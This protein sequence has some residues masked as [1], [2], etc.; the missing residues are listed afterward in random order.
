[1]EMKTESSNQQDGNSGTQGVN[2]RTFV[3]Q[4]S[5]TAGSVFPAL[6]PATVL[7]KNPPSERIQLAAFGFGTRGSYVNTSMAHF[8]DARYVAVCDAFGSRRERA[9]Q[10]LDGL[11]GGDYVK[12]YSNPWDV[13]ERNDIDA[14]VICTPDHW[15]VP[16]AIAAAKAKK[17]MYVE[18]PLSYAMAW[19]WRLRDELKRSGGVF[20]YGTMQRSTGATSPDMGTNWR[21]DHFRNVCE[22]VRNGYIGKIQR[23]DVW[24]PDI[25]SQFDKFSCKQWGSLRPIEPPP[26]LDV[27]LWCGPSPLR[28]YT[29]DRCTG[30]GTCHCEESSLGFI[31]GWGAHPLDTMQWGLDTDNTA[32]VYY[33]GGGTIPKFGL[34]RTVDTWDVTCYYAN[35]ISVRF[36]SDRVAKEMLTY[37]K[38]WSIHGTTFFGTDG[39]ISVDRGG[40]EAS[41]ESLLTAKLGP[42]DKPLYDSGDHGRNFL[43][44][45]RSRKPT[46]S[47]FDCGMHSDTISHMANIVVRSG[48][49]VAFDPQARKIL[50]DPEQSRMLDRPMR[51]KWAI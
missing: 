3:K 32:P 28:P 19:T 6:V 2:R 10:I 23:V 48:R 26:D 14:V 46:I 40:V 37:R 38:R 35:G 31:A 9:K 16:L 44:C 36:M 22:L 41:K 33:E 15:H 34:F 12:L 13:F 39:W 27:N 29:A 50:N 49:P 17:D 21:W 5:L 18:K 43:D 20:Q 8:P 7:G 51:K 24:A 30:L 1:M 45:I 4:A 11:S 47:P 25:G 42:N